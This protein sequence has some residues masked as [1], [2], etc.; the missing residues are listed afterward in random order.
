MP[1][2]REHP[3]EDEASD[4]AP[5]PADSRPKRP[6]T[7]SL[8][9]GADERLAELAL[10]WGF[11]WG[12]RGNPSALVAAVATGELAPMR[13]DAA[14]LRALQLAVS[15]L[16]ED[17]RTEDART[18]LTLL[19][20]RGA[21]PPGLHEGLRSQL[22]ALESPSRRELERWI[23]ARLPFL[24][25]Y[26]N[27][28]GEERELTVVHARIR[29]EERRSYLEVRALEQK[30]NREIKPLRDNWVLRLDRVTAAQPLGG[31]GDEGAPSP[32]A[33][34]V[35]HTAPAP[36]S[37]TWAEGLASL[38]A[39]LRLT[40]SLAHTYMR[41]PDDVHHALEEDFRTG[42]RILTVKREVT[43]SFWFLRDVLRH[44]GDC[45]VV[46]PP[47]LRELVAREA[48]RAAATYAPPSA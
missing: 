19:T 12:K 44:G 10:E 23:A 33:L 38:T 7:L 20:Q 48:R 40:G 34:E 18:L 11:R 26:R 29:P 1:R 4:A 47:E 46:D 16:A 14:T 6:L 2:K 3:V 42:Q 24:L 28:L 31:D 35:E 25:R 5:H 45:E 36:A 9:E 22:E 13:L 27:R 30:G 8:P 32:D 17:G 21:A 15:A 43:S 39:T 37:V 41:R